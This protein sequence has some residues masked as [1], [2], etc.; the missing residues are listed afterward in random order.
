LENKEIRDII[1]GSEL[2]EMAEFLT[3]PQNHIVDCILCYQTDEDV[4]Y[5]TL[6]GSSIVALVGLLQMADGEL[7]K[8]LNGMFKEDE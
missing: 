5:W 7:H 6:S 3:D 8:I 1:T 4:G 2:R